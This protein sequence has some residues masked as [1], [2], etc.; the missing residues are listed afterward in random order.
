MLDLALDYEVQKQLLDIVTWDNI[1][2]ILQKIK[3]RDD[4]RFGIGPRGRNRVSIIEQDQDGNAKKELLPSIDNL[5]LGESTLLN[6]FVNIIRHGDNPP[7]TTQQIQGIV[8]IDEIDA[9]LHTDLQNSVLPELIKLFPKIQF[10]ITT[11]S[12]LFLLG[13]NKVFGEDGFEIRNMPKGEIITTERFSEF[14]H[15]YNVFKETEKFE[16]EI[17][18]QIKEN[19]KPILLLEGKTDKKILETAWSKLN[20]NQNFPYF[21]MDIKDGHNAKKLQFQ[22]ENADLFQNDFV[23]GI[24]DF[25]EEGWNQWNGLKD[26]NK[27]ENSEIIKKHKNKNYFA[28]LLPCLEKNFKYSSLKNQIFNSEFKSLEKDTIFEIEHMFYDY[29][30]EKI[31]NEY[32]TK[33]SIYG[34]ERIEFQKTKKVGFCEFICNNE[35]KNYF[36]NFENI[37]E[38]IK[39]C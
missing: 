17:K 3:K 19:K 29:L 31:K 33:E 32:F 28:L 37:F 34:G 1:K 2:L 21:I 13:T 25:D 4:I 27:L 7:K 30:D 26:W 23:F 15:A 24:F 16:E 14:E 11:H 35:T 18:E 6:L 38:I 12:P 36:K 20:K 9:H 10:I 39:N 8:A 22:L 5:S